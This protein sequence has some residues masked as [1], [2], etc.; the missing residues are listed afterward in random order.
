MSK[1]CPSD[2]TAPFVAN[3]KL[4]CLPP[5]RAVPFSRPLAPTTHQISSSLTCF[6][7]P[8]WSAAANSFFTSTAVQPSSTLAG[9]PSQ[10]K[11]RFPGHHVLCAF[12][13]PWPTAPTC[14]LLSFREQGGVCALLQS[15]HSSH[16]AIC[17]FD[18][19]LPGWELRKH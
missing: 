4:D 3:F 9:D 13:L 18:C 14:H 10:F 2:A 19:L 7:C 16:S 17:L 15:W 11:V 6:A 12:L 8:G 5:S 1:S